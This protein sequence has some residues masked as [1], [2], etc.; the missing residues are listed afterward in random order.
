MKFWGQNRPCYHGLFVVNWQQQK[1][2]ELSR[3]F[4][5]KNGHKVGIV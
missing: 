1:G 3:G 2:Y 5:Y 4:F